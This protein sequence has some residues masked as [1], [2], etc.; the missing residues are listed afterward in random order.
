MGGAVNQVAKAAAVVASPVV[1]TAQ[2]AGNLA[3]GESLKDSILS[4]VRTIVEGGK[5]TAKIAAAGGQEVGLL[6]KPPEGINI[7]MVDPAQ[8]KTDDSAAR[9]RAKRQAEIDL[10]TDRPGRGGTILTDNYSYKV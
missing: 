8:A 4:P 3:S 5:G 2:M 7:G 9:A 6:P 10:L 1:A